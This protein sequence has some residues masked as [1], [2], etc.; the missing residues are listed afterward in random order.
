MQQKTKALI[1]AAGMRLGYHKCKEDRF[2][3]SIMTI[4]IENHSYTKG[5]NIGWFKWSTFSLFFKYLFFL[6]G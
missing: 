2:L 3:M 4:M 5:R 1:A 6:C